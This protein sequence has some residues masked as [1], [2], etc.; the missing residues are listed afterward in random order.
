MS[1]RA[2]LA[3]RGLFA[4]SAVAPFLPSLLGSVPGFGVFGAALDAWFRFQCERDPGRSFASVAVCARCLGIYA[5][6]GLGGALGRPALPLRRVQVWIA[7]AVLLL[8]LD[9]GSEALG[10]RPPSAG[11]RLL[12]G[13]L[14][15]YPVGLIVRAALVSAPRA[16]GG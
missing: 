5:G 8:A 7:A 15:A 9:L 3:L 6:F 13:F 16:A 2:E 11:L 14:L 10:Y 4:F 12:T 1:R